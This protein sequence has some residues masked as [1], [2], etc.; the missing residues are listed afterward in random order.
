[1]ASTNQ[2][3]APGVQSIAAPLR[4]KAAVVALSTALRELARGRRQARCELVTPNGERTAIP[5]AVLHV[6]E[7][8]TEVLARGDA[9]AIVPLRTELT[10]QQAANLLNVSR[11]YLVR[12]LDEGSV[13]STKTG[14]HRRVRMDDLLRFK[15]KRDADRKA[16]LDELSQLGE[17]YAG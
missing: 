3:P 17:E 4:Q 2:Q 10:T 13:P 5:E 11:Q 1:M 12:L 9:V 6:L 14:T 8:A 15:A 7:V 16:K